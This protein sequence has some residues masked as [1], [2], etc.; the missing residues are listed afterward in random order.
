MKKRKPLSISDKAV[1][2]GYNLDGA[3]VYSASMSLG[4]YYDGDH[5]WDSSDQIRILM[6]QRVHGYLFGSEGELEQEFET[7]F[8]TSS[9]EYLKSWARFSDGT[10]K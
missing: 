1:L 5:P 2:I 8:D 7:T 6:L 3:C 10:V 9:G 4:K